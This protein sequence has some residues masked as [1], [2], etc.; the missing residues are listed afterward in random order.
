MKN[1]WKLVLGAISCL[2]VMWVIAASNNQTYR[3]NYSVY[4]YNAVSEQLEYSGA[5]SC[6]VT[7]DGGKSVKRNNS[8]VMEELWDYELTNNSA[9]VA[10][11]ISINVLI[12]I[13]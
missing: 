3:A 10:D 13:D 2:I 7:I 12:R 4:K 9:F 11:S 1:S 6:V 5:R 8:H